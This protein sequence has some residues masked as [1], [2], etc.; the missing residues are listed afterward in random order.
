MD[1]RAVP[2]KWLRHL[3]RRHVVDLKHYFAS[4]LRGEADRPCKMQCCF[5]GTNK[6]NATYH[7]HAVGLMGSFGW[8]C[9][10][11]WV[12]NCVIQRI[13]S[14]QHNAIRYSPSVCQR[15]QDQQLLI[16]LLPPPNV[17]CILN[18][19]P[20]PPRSAWVYTQVH[21]ST[22]CRTLEPLSEERTQWLLRSGTQ[23]TNS[24]YSFQFKP[25]RLKYC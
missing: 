13:P 23:I 4:P 14:G 11:Q 18:G 16:M 17:I 7:E 22:S 2:L 9:A 21:T 24:I 25:L 1:F 15:G 12:W 10:T 19:Q 6:Q 8:H 3:H 20:A 5:D